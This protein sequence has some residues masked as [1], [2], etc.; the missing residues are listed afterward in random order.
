MKNFIELISTLTLR[1]KE[2][3]ASQL[4][5][6]IQGPVWTE[7]LLY[8]DVVLYNSEKTIYSTLCNYYLGLRRSEEFARVQTY[9][10]KWVTVCMDAGTV[11]Q[12][13]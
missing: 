7:M 2:V 1:D 10:K 5:S 3:H 13:Q 11:L 6:T 12:R 9:Q 8:F 4:C